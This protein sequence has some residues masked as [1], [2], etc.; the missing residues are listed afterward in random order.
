[1]CDNSEGVKHKY[2]S[3]NL[4]GVDKHEMVVPGKE[5]KGVG[6]KWGGVE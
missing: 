6:K 4:A 5:H 1:L 2:N 3:E